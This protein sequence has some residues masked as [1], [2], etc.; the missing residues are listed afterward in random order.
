MKRWRLVAD[1]LTVWAF[2]VLIQAAVTMIRLIR[3]RRRDGE[4]TP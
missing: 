4:G 1:R 2:Y 3:R